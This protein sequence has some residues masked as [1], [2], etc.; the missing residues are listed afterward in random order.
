MIIRVRDVVSRPLWKGD[1]LFCLPVPGFIP[2]DL[3]TFFWSWITSNFN[4]L[5]LVKDFSHLF[6]LSTRSSPSVRFGWTIRAGLLCAGN[7][8]RRVAAENQGPNRVPRITLHSLCIIS[9][10]FLFP[11]LLIFFGVCCILHGRSIAKS[12]A[13]ESVFLYLLI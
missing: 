6:R 3:Y 12:Y 5:F 11:C 10:D 9:F 2:Y 4:H 1:L 13:M 7:T 8:L